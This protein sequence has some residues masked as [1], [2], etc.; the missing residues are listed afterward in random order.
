MSVDTRKREF[1]PTCPSGWAPPP[2]PPGRDAVELI[3]A[4]PRPGHAEALED[5]T[6]RPVVH[7]PQERWGTDPWGGE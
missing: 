1:P 4:A 2:R 5:L 6:Q 7:R 3:E